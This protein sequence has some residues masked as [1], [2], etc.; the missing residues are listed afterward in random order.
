[1]AFRST[2]AP[3]ALTCFALLGSSCTKRIAP[4]EQIRR[5][6]AA[7]EAAVEEKDLDE[8]A[9][10]I[11]AKYGDGEQNDKKTVVRLLQFQFIRYPVIHLLVRT[12]KIELSGAKSARAKIFVAMASAPMTS[13]SDLSRYQADLYR[14]DFELEDDGGG[15]RWQVVQAGWDRAVPTDFVFDP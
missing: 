5:T 7:I 1:L 14:F 12:D 3:F 6:I 15:A 2:I 11:A 13:S 8:V 9:K 10:F 4:E